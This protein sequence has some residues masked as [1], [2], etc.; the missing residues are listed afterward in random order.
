[1]DRCLG[2]FEH[3]KKVLNKFR[4]RWE[5]DLSE[6]TESVRAKD[7]KSI[8][9]SAHALKGTAAILSAEALREAASKLEKIGRSGNLG[10]AE[11]CLQELQ[12]AYSDCIAFLPEAELFIGGL[13]AARIRR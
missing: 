1:L 4:D 3:F 10:E 11:S 12:Q 2:N 5:Q 8:T 7:A 13:V 9:A 6:I